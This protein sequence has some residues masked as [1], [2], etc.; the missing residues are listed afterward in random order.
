MPILLSLITIAIMVITLI[1]VIRR[2]DSEVKYLPKIFWVIL[3]IIIPLVG[4]IVWWAIGREYPQQIVVR[5]PQQ[6]T[7]R[8]RE[9]QP[10]QPRIV[11]ERSTEQQIADL[12][13][14][15]EEWRLKEEL[16]RRQ[17]ER[18]DTQD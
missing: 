7:Q 16:R 17:E 12:D 18:R 2:D 9:E 14:E 1:D 10:R 4:S 3:V 13:R 11:D 15:I 6:S 5:R 8:Y